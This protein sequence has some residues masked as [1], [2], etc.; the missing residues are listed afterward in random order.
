[1]EPTRSSQADARD[2]TTTPPSDSPSK[3]LSLT[4]VHCSHA[5]QSRAATQTAKTG[6]DGKTTLRECH[7]RKCRPASASTVECYPGQFPQAG[8]QMRKKN[9][10]LYRHHEHSNGHTQ[11][12]RMD[13]DRTHC[14][15][16]A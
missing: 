10:H 6:R 4:D 16:L 7:R 5:E 8:G 13:N 3:T 12:K 14:N 1:M 2:R 9:C 11:T 15:R